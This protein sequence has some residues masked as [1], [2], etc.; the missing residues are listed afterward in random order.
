ML[1]MSLSSY[2]FMVLKLIILFFSIDKSEMY[3]YEKF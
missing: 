1:L 3:I 2:N